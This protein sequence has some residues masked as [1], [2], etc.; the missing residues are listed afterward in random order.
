MRPVC[1]NDVSKYESHSD[2]IT[3]K[4]AKSIPGSNFKEDYSYY[5]S[6]ESL[7]SGEERSVNPIYNNQK[8]RP[9]VEFRSVSICIEDEVIKLKPDQ[10]FFF[11]GGCF[12]CLVWHWLSHPEGNLEVHQ[13]QAP[14]PFRILL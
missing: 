3:L 1:E 10:N 6:E 14:K 11:I 7:D 8:N 4:T 12:S 2:E 9:K 5:N 13:Q